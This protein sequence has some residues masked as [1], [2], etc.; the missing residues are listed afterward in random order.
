MVMAL[1]LEM[2][3]NAASLGDYPTAI[4]QS[5]ELAKTARAKADEL[6][7]KG[8]LVLSDAALKDDARNAQLG[9]LKG[10]KEQMDAV[11]LQATVE[12]V[13]TLWQKGR[14]SEALSEQENGVALA[15]KAKDASKSII[16]NNAKALIYSSMG[17]TDQ[18]VATLMETLEMARQ[19]GDRS[20]QAVVLQQP[21]RCL[22]Q[23]R[24][25]G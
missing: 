20:E 2:V 9:A 22:S 10:Q 5:R 15:Q 4:A 18:A 13:N 21:G 23:G 7:A 6:I 14:L 16:F 17:S 11:V 3:R 25:I 8:R 19:L 1:K 12:L 24:E